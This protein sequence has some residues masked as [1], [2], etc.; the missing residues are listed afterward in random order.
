M[1]NAETE[2]EQEQYTKLFGRDVKKHIKD[3]A[4]K[5]ILPA[6]GTVNFAVISNP[7]PAYATRCKPV[8][9]NSPQPKQCPKCDG[10]FEPATGANS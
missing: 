8:G 10:I 2:A 6:E 5:Y 3:I 9:C 4:R 7:S 1:S